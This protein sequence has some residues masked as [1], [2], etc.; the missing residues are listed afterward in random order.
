MSTSTLTKAKSM[1]DRLL[2]TPAGKEMVRQ[3]E[4]SEARQAAR[5]R[6]ADRLAELP[7]EWKADQAKLRAEFEAATERRDALQAE[8]R[9]A[10]KERSQAAR[11]LARAR[12]RADR[13][14]DRIRRD[15]STDADPEIGAVIAAVKSYRE[16]LVATPFPK[17]TPRKPRFR[18]RW[19]HSLEPVGPVAEGRERELRELD[20]A[21]KVELPALRFAPDQGEIAERL[22]YWRSRAAAD[23]K[24]S[25]NGKGG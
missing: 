16:K 2:T 23:P 6:L 7:A 19:H 20:D 13:E 17:G 9:A 14:R 5:D 12:Q 11:A 18:S 4:A 8:L 21:V 3:L 24:L 25:T 1:F 15:L 22:D 10:E